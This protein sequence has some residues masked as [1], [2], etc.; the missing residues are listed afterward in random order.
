MLRV[1]VVIDQEADDLAA[2]VAAAPPNLRRAVRLMLGAIDPISSIAAARPGSVLLED[3][4]K[5]EVVPR[6]ALLNIV[7]AAP[8]GTPVHW[9]KAPH[10]LNRAAYHDAFDWLQRRLRP[11]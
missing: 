8:N 2:F 1:A 6:T 3:G 11:S 4:T 5:D 10:A 9:Y 7:G